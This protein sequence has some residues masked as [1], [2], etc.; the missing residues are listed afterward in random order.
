MFSHTSVPPRSLLSAN[1]SLLCVICHVVKSHVC[2]MKV[3]SVLSRHVSVTCHVR[4]MSHTYEC[5]VKSHVS[6]LSHTYECQVKSVSSH[7][8][9]TWVSSHMSHTYECHVKSHVNVLL[10]SVKYHVSSQIT[11]VSRQVMWESRVMSA[12][13][14]L[15]NPEKSHSHKLVRLVK[16]KSIHLFC[17]SVFWQICGCG[18][19][20]D[21][22]VRLQLTWHVTLT[23]SKTGRHTQ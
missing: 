4:L 12:A 14:E 22:G 10:L 15:P 2:H 18:I 8:T 16:Q 11:W 9:H 17:S 20:Q 23:C 21:L 6:V 7:V 13:N 5:H 19:S 3:M 1:V